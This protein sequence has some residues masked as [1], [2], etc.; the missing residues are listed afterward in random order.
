MSVI[1]TKHAGIFGSAPVDAD[2]KPQAQQ[3]VKP[4]PATGSPADVMVRGNRAESSV[5]TPQGL[6]NGLARPRGD[7]VPTLPNGALVTG[8]PAVDKAPALAPQRAEV[9]VDAGKGGGFMRLV[10]HAAIWWGFGVGDADEDPKGPA[11]LT[12]DEIR[13]DVLPQLKPGDVV[14]MGSRGAVTHAAVYA[15]DGKV[16]HSMATEETQRSIFQRI[17]DLFVAPFSNLAEWLHLKKD[18]QGVFDERLDAFVDRFYRD[19]YVVLR[20]DA[21]GV[22]Q[23]HKG[24][25]ALRASLG[26][27]Y[28]WDLVPGNKTLYC[29]ELVGV[30][31]RAALA[32][33]APRIGARPHKE[34]VAIMDRDGY[35]D[36]LDVLQSPDLR[37]VL[38][39]EAARKKYPTR[40]A[41]LG[42]A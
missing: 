15:G 41:H 2:A 4:Q 23:A 9:V 38:A 26:T 5:S 6:V 35:V 13:R 21:L 27:G 19:S 10:R 3:V 12:G 29:T 32:D 25:A 42:P 11:R 37:A 14:L 7:N 33:D 28:D 8:D 16:I 18:R 20:S 36:P 22:E 34:H 24:L 40:L 1:S 30:F 39:N 31:Y 17:L